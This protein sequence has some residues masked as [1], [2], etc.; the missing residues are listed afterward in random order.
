[1][2]DMCASCC[3]YTMLDLLR[4]YLDACLELTA[5]RSVNCQISGL[6]EDANIDNDID[7][8]RSRLRINSRVEIVTGGVLA[9]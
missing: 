9:A 7:L 6:R 8:P 5:S 1:M 4:S 2:S 3:A